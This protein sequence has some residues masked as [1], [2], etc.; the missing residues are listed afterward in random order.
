MKLNTKKIRAEM[1]RLGIN[2]AE[3]ARRARITPA[4]LSWLLINRRTTFGTLGKIARV[5]LLDPK[6]LLT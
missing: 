3:L 1:A 6:D 2:Q 5:F 4:A